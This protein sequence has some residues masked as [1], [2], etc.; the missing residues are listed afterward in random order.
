MILDDEALVE[1][2]IALV[3]R[4]LETRPR[5][6][7]QDALWLEAGQIV[8]LLPR[9]VDADTIA[10]RDV[11]MQIH[12]DRGYANWD[13]TKLDRGDFDDQQPMLI[14]KAAIRRGRQL[15]SGAEQ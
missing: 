5:S 3:K 11:V 4:M 6:T 7:E 15:A 2:I 9:S 14:A 8:A 10:A 13:R 12:K 1:R